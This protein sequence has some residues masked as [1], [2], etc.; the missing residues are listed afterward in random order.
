VGLGRW[1]AL[2]VSATVMLGISATAAQAESI[3]TPP[4]IT[5]YAEF[6]IAMENDLEF[7]SS[8]CLYVP[9]AITFG[10]SD[11]AIVLGE[12]TVTRPGTDVLNEGTFLIL[13]ADPVFGTRLDE[14][15]VCPADGSGEFKLAGQVV[16]T[17]GINEVVAAVPELTF[18]VKRTPSAI[19]S[20]RAS[21]NATG[22]VVQGKAVANGFPATGIARIQVKV[23]GS[24]KWSTAI[25]APIDRRGAFSQVLA[26]TVPHGSL[27]RATLTDCSWCGRSSASTRL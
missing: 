24:K 9:V 16:V 11:E 4:V 21:T 13:P 22:V 18:Y 10:R 7:Q 23:P 15:Y 8:S 26:R 3:S 14:V 12:L 25:S 6:S 2:G 5:P 1:V 19:R 20:L 17:S 27:I